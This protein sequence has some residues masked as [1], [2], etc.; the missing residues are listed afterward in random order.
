MT[1]FTTDY[2]QPG[3]P[4]VETSVR[5]K[6]TQL[7]I[8]RNI[9]VNS[10]SSRISIIHANKFNMAVHSTNWWMPI[11]EDDRKLVRLTNLPL[12]DKEINLFTT[13]ID[14]ILGYVDQL[15]KVDTKNIDPTFNVSGQSNIERKDEVGTCLPQEDALKNASQKNE[16]FFITKGVFNN[17]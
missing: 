16:Q 15:E 12:T 4:E 3:V 9:G 11:S 7:E 5:I 6:I 1:S 2:L 13:Q 10:V 14:A 8:P 17:E